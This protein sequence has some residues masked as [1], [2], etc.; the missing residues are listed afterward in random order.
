MIVQ[1]RDIILVH[2]RM[3]ITPLGLYINKFFFYRRSLL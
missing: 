1:H 3:D 2:G